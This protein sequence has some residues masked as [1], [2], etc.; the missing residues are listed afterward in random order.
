M[1]RTIQRHSSPVGAAQSAVA[2]APN[3]F[4]GRT[5]PARN[6]W[7]SP[8]VQNVL[9]FVT[10]LTMHAAIICIGLLTYKAITLVAAPPAD[11]TYIIP[12]SPIISDPATSADKIDFGTGRDRLAR[13]LQDKTL[14]VPDMTGSAKFVGA[15]QLRM[16]GG[17]G[18]TESA[19]LVIGV[20][21]GGPIGQKSPGHSGPGNGTDN[22]PGD[23]L[24]AFGVPLNHATGPSGIGSP[25][26]H[27]GGGARKIVYVC[28]ASGS[29]IQKLQPLKVELTKAVMGLRPIQG[30]NL[31]FFRA[32]SIP[33]SFSR[34]LAAAK[35]EVKAKAF[36][37]L[38]DVTA[39]GETNPLPGIKQ[40]F[41]QKPEIIF[42]LT[43]GDFPDND[44][45]L[46]EIRQLNKEHKVRIN[47]IAFVGQADTD[48]K[49]KELL[50]T[51]AKEN[52][53]SYKFVTPDDL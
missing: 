18:E 28:D 19:D 24:A 46:D 48:V 12:D 50:Q 35:P 7:Q 6:F 26:F 14:D 40:A 3:P 16:P 53:G 17:G 13:L 27:I 21:P 38:D 32:E 10:S 44:A 29:M 43:D 2:D 37:F 31:I 25:I 9:P 20:G 39:S 8:T 15:N 23:A 51:I 45:V 5:D 49:F 41:Q 30:F 52:G 33:Q 11:A 22:G 4:D 34:D 42:L 36:R 47:T 1:S